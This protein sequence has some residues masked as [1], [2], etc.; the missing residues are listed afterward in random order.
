MSKNWMLFLLA[1]AMMAAARPAQAASFQVGSCLPKL[2]KFSTI[3]AAVSSVPPFSTI[4]VCPGVYREQVTI[5]QPLTLRGQGISNADRPVIALPPNGIVVNVTSIVF[6][7][8]SYS[9][10][11]LV[12]NVNPPGPVSIIDMTVDGSGDN[13][14][15]AEFYGLAGIFFTSGSSGSVTGDTVR[16]QQD[17]GCGVGIWIET[18]GAAPQKITIGNNS[19]HD[20]DDDGIVALSNQNPPTLT[21][22]IEKNVVTASGDTVGIFTVGIGGTITDN[23]VTGV[24]IGIY[25]WDFFPTTPGITI[26]SNTVADIQSG[27]GKFSGEGTGIFVRAGSTASM[28]KVSNAPTGFALQASAD[29]SSSSGPSLIS[30]ATENTTLAVEFSCIPGPVLKSNTFNDS[31]T[32]FDKVPTGFVIKPTANPYYNIDTIQTGSCP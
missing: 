11:V 1:V 8:N 2:P 16:G 24:G 14:G 5:S 4:L 7:T 27:S 18:A 26:S 3:Q 17:G 21:A 31:Q 22:T 28:N 25:E 32:G 23:V 10:Q 15:C 13:L 30:N 12:Q 6:P 19:V 20:F 9:A 29:G